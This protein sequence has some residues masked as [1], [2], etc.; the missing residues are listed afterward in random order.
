MS[1]NLPNGIAETLGDTLV[2]SS[3]LFITGDLHYVDSSNAA[4]DDSAGYG[5][6]KSRPFATLA[7][8]VSV[9]SGGDIVVLLEGH[10]EQFATELDITQAL[11]IVAAGETDGVPTVTLN[12]LA[13][14][15]YMLRLSASGC[16]LRNIRFVQHPSASGIPH[17][18]I[19]ASGCRIIG[20]RF[21]AG[22]DNSAYCVTVNDSLVTCIKDCTFISVSDDPANQPTGGLLGPGLGTLF[23]D[24]CVFDDGDVGYSSFAFRWT[25]APRIHASGCSFLNGAV[26]SGGEAGDVFFVGGTMTGGVQLIEE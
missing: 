2:T 24:N 17:V 4:A 15:G 9:A 22:E 1:R 20:C 5:E 7:Y 6:S 13:A 26:A 19:A 10:S 25:T 3:P 18:N 23:L 16:E 21:E 14:S 12:N 11:T 8:A